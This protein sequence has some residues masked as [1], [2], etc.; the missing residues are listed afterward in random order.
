VAQHVAT[1]SLPEQIGVGR[2]IVVEDDDSVVSGITMDPA[3]RE[4]PFPFPGTFDQMDMLDEEDDEDGPP[5][6][7]VLRRPEPSV[8]A[9]D[10]FDPRP[11]HRK[12]S[13]PQPQ[14]SGAHMM[15]PSQEMGGSARLSRLRPGGDLAAPPSPSRPTLN[16]LHRNLRPTHMPSDIEE[17]NSAALKMSGGSSD[18]RG[19]SSSALPFPAHVVT[20]DS[21]ED[22]KDNAQLQ[23]YDDDD[24]EE[25]VEIEAPRIRADY[26]PNISPNP[27][28][29]QRRNHLQPFREGTEEIK[30]VPSPSDQRLLTNGRAQSSKDAFSSWRVNQHVEHTLSASSPDL[31]FIPDA[32]DPHP[33]PRP[34]DKRSGDLSSIPSII[35]LLVSRGSDAKVRADAFQ[36]LANLIWINGDEAKLMVQ[37]N[38][39]IESIVECMWEDLSNARVQNEAVDL[40]FALSACSEADLGRDIFMGGSARNA[41]DALL[42]SMQTHIS[43]ESLQKSGCGALGCL[44]SACKENDKVDDG[45]LSGAVSCVAA[46]MDA[47]RKSN[48]IQKWG[49][50]ALQCQCVL[51][52]NYENSQMML[53]KGASE[54]GGLK[55]IFR[56][57]ELNDTDIM[58]L[59]WGCKL[60]WSLSYNNEICGML[61]EDNRI[62]IVIMKVLRLFQGAANVEVEDLQEAAYG[63]LANISRIKKTH[64]WLREAGIIARIFESMDAHKSSARVNTEACALVA[65]LLDSP[66]LK[67]AV[68]SYGIDK[69]FRAMDTFPNS[70]ELHQEAMR[71]LLCLSI[72]SEEAKSELAKEQ[73][74][75]II[76]TS[77]ARH[78][79]SPS[80]LEKGFAVLSSLCLGKS[81]RHMKFGDV[82]DLLIQAMQ[83]YPN[84]RR[85]QEGVSLL[86]RNL[87]CRDEE[88]VIESP[89]FFAC[90][91]NVMKTQA[92]SDKVQ[93]N[94]CCVLSNLFAMEQSITC[95]TVDEGMNQIVSIIQSHIE[96]AAVL[97]MACEAV[98]RLISSTEQCK[99]SF[100][101]TGGAEYVKT[102]LLMHPESPNTLEKAIAVLACLSGSPAHCTLVSNDQGICYVVETMR[103]QSTQ[104]Q[105]LEY[106]SIVLR[107]LVLSSVDNAP[108]AS[109]GISTII[110]ALKDNPTA[111]SFQIEACHALWVMAAQSE[112]CRQKIIALDGHAI[113]LQLM[114]TDGVEMEAR[115][116]IRGVVNQVS[117]PVR[118]SN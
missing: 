116:A 78:Y 35:R 33:R 56:A 53:S 40:L 111:T 69:I 104:L 71:T 117:I 98:C 60:Y 13:R 2:D 97:E 19:S 81:A 17:E 29:Q 59:E 52:R 93:M 37:R 31:Q 92:N 109:G 72:N 86:F 11:I 15:D 47:H 32:S 34:P 106:A 96:S 58:S 39:G 76:L 107:N 57:M 54:A 1:M 18:L 30:F 87:S 118:S 45:T 74:L 62:I 38:H 95:S 103:A 61:T 36:K 14:Q 27:H 85:L 94:L 16:P 28:Q 102:A 50:W 46:A 100:V 26:M 5:P 75:E 67:E 112:D 105:L 64:T 114:D 82:V 77:I 115:E 41:I 7:R 83:N 23:Y 12:D 10:A 51:S 22:N 99:R 9:E 90:L 73:N 49:L 48:E 108:E 88:L 25:K 91:L 42:I 70:E 21:N 101:E 65:N 24:R 66:P 110:S 89:D 43:I 8:C 4:I 63:A 84:E 113:L 80:L 20:T 79:Q 68:L 6:P 44:A 3:L 55:V